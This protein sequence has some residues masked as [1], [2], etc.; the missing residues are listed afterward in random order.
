MA[1]RVAGGVI[2]GID[3]WSPSR[4]GMFLLFPGRRRSMGLLLDYARKTVV[5]GLL[6]LRVAQPAPQAPVSAFN[7]QAL[8][9]E[10]I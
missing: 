2:R 7:Q 8:D 1:S 9:V 6:S 5:I 3:A 4:G 10:N